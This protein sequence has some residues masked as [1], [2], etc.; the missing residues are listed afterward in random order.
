MLTVPDALRHRGATARFTFQAK[1]AFGQFALFVE[2][3]GA[4]DV[5]RPVPPMCTEVE[6]MFTQ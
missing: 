1:S 5:V 6:L 2:M 4:F 3:H